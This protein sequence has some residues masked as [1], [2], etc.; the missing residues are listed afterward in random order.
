MTRAPR[1]HFL[2]VDTK[3]PYVHEHE[4]GDFGKTVHYLLRWQNAKGQPGPW[5]HVVSTKISG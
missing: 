1:H 4:T 3:T 5:G 2:A